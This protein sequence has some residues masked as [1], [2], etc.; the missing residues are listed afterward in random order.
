MGPFL[1]FPST[2]PKIKGTDIHLPTELEKEN[3]TKWLFLLN[4]LQTLKKGSTTAR[5]CRI[6]IILIMMVSMMIMMN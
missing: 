3:G 6:M 2:F 4:T 1:S 5:Q